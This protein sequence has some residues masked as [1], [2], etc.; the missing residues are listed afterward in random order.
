MG[1]HWVFGGEGLFFAVLAR[2]GKSMVAITAHQ[3]LASKIIPIHRSSATAKKK[4]GILAA[5][6]TVEATDLNLTYLNKTGLH[7]E[8]CFLLLN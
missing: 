5:S 1:A 7:R 8:P 4:E 2:P 6:A 3:P